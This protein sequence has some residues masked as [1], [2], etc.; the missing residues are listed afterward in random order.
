MSILRLLGR[1]E[2]QVLQLRVCG[3]TYAEIAQRLTIEESTVAVHLRNARRKLSAST[4][5]EA[6]A[7]VRQ[8]TEPEKGPCTETAGKRVRDGSR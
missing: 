2:H 1:R 8:Q 4:I 3:A 6:I 5:E 7:I